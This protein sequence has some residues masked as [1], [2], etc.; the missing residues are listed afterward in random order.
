MWRLALAV[1]ALVYFASAG[2]FVLGGDNGEFASIF[3]LGGVPHP[4]G[5]PA[6]SLYLRAMSWVPGVSAAHGAALA[7]CFIGVGAVAVIR[8]ACQAWGASPLSS[9]LTA[10]VIGLS[11]LMWTMSTHAEVFALHA[12]LAA[13]VLYVAGPG[14]RLTLGRRAFLLGLLAGLGLSN[15][16]SLVTIAPLGLFAAYRVVRNSDSASR[17]LALG[18]GGL[19]LGLST[20]L[21]LFLAAR[22]AP[23]VDLQW[24]TTGDLAGLWHHFIRGDYGTTQLAISDGGSSTLA[25]VTR[26][27]IELTVNLRYFPMVLALIGLQTMLTPW[28]ARAALKSASAS[29]AAS[30]PKPLHETTVRMEAAREPSNTGSVRQPALPPSYG[31]VWLLTWL[32]AGP[33]FVGCFNLPLEGLATIIVDRFYLLPMVLLCV[34]I[35]RGFDQ[36]M[37]RRTSALEI[38]SPLMVAVLSL[39]VV[40][41]LEPVREH[42]REDVELYLINTLETVAPESV[43]LGT[44]DH[45]VYGF[46][47]VRHVLGVRPDVIYVDVLLLSYPW[48][49]A[50]IEAELGRELEGVGV[51]SVNTVEMASD[52]YAAGHSIYLTNRF[53]EAI[54][55]QAPNYPIGT[56]IRIGAPPGPADLETLNASVA[57]SY[58]YPRS[59]P[60]DPNGWAAAVEAEYTRPWRV[61]EEY[62]D[63]IGDTESAAR[64]RNR[65]VVIPR[66]Q[67]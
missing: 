62:Y 19:A 50:R 15:N 31:P 45:R 44:G 58:T 63:S 26:L 22:G 47:Y 49:Q 29:G 42:H 1:L 12:L 2:R 35:A 56:L 66:S 55:T 64:C 52:L 43:I 25:H 65:G 40:V 6:Y 11:P 13:S 36:L 28:G 4:S 51:R 30:T 18:V 23:G 20:Y 5:Y 59:A 38:Y 46:H 39:G 57:N 7:T 60:H 33:V 53:S 10:L 9:T 32:C 48:Y 34:P 67:L 14:C 8:G 37:G 61:L 24:G 16:H 27:L 3:A 17:A 54:V 41:G 21:Y